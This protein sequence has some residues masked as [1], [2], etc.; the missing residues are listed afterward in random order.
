MN[1]RSDAPAGVLR[2]G[3]GAGFSGDRWDAAL[4]VV[5]TLADAG[6]PAALMYETL[7]ERTLALA[8]LRRRENPAL[9]WEPTL[10]RFLIPVLAPC[11][12][13]GIPIVGNFGA[14]NPAGAAARVQALAAQ[15][16]LPRLRIAVVQ[17]DDL[18]AAL[19]AQQLAAVLPASLRGKELVSANAYLGAFEIAQAL[20]AG[21]QVVVTGRV[22]DPALAL[23]PMLA[24]FGWGLED[25]D[26]LGA[27][28]MAGHLLECGAQVTGGY[29]ADPGIKDVPDLA[30]VGFPIVEMHADGR[31]VVGK[32]ARTGG[33][34][35]RRT[36]IEQL[37]YE[38]HDP[39]AYL[40]P[41]VVADI[42]RCSV[43]EL[44]SDRVE[45]RGVRGHARPA[46]LK[47]TV[48]REGGWLAEGEISYAGPQA[49]ARAR[50]AGDIVTQRLQ[51][52]GL[53][54]LQVRQDLIGV[55]SVFADDA[56]R[57]WKDQPQPPSAPDV[58]LRIAA[59]ADRRSDAEQVVREV[60]ALY[61]CGPAG[62]G[63]VRTT[64]TPRLASDSCFVP[65]EWVQPSWSFHP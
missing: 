56:G 28:T 36:V 49:A 62:G 65:R 30:N 17:G 55:A 22:A 39:A 46:T 1:T 9:G 25:W 51:M 54:A 53:G 23:G 50:L 14:A 57:W 59:A 64:I 4:P 43:T 48:C 8:Q 12:E 10:D 27:G 61:T 41:D 63:G 7:A 33:C 6:G 24:H 34:V 47:A 5:R 35:T 13:A 58:R 2:I 42:T 44:Q 60:T 38:I 32:A 19:P 16:G 45:V 29:F 21:A 31:F 52:L 3:C 37:L 20:R 26:L 18:L 11:V 40:T 15:L